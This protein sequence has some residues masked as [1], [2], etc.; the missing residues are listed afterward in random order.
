MKD[1]YV[2]FYIVLMC[3]SMEE[4]E[5]ILSDDWLLVVVLIRF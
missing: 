1:E 2:F 5:L 4:G 3:G